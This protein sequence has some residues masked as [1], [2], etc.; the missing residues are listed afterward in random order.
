MSHALA[1]PNSLL[2]LLV[3][4][5]AFVGIS[6][7]NVLV[8]PG[9]DNLEVGVDW[10]ALD[11]NDDAL[12]DTQN[13]GSQN[14]VLGTLADGK[15]GRACWTFDLDDT[16]DP[17]AVVSA[18]LH[19]QLKTK[20]G[21]LPANASLYHSQTSTVGGSNATPSQRAQIYHDASFVD[22]G[23]DLAEPS[24]PNGWYSFDVTSQVISDL[25]N[26]AGDCLA[27]FR[28]NIDGVERTSDLAPGNRYVFASA[29]DLPAIRPYLE[30][31]LADAL[32]DT[33]VT[34]AGDVVR[35]VKQVGDPLE[36]IDYTVTNTGGQPASFTVREAE[37]CDWM[38]LSILGSSAPLDPNE[39]L[40][41]TVSFDP[42]GLSPGVY[43]GDIVFVNTCDP[44]D[45]HTSQVTL[46]YLLNPTQPNIVIIFF[47]DLRAQE[48]NAWGQS[49]IPSL[50]TSPNID[51]LA[52]EGLR[53]ANTFPGLPVCTPSRATL[54]TG[55]MPFAVRSLSENGRWMVGNSRY[56]DPNE[57]TFAEQLN[58]LGYDT[59]FVGKWHLDELPNLSAIPPERRQGWT[60]MTGFQSYGRLTDAK[61]FEDD[62]TLVEEP[63][64][65][66]PD[67]ELRYALEFIED[68]QVDPFCLLL[69]HGPPHSP[70]APWAEEHVIEEV[71]TPDR[72]Y[73]WDMFSS[74]PV[75]F[76][77]NMTANPNGYPDPARQIRMYHALLRGVDEN[78]AIVRNKLETLGLAD[79]TIVIFFSDHGVQLGSFGTWEKNV[80]YEESILCPLVIYDPRP[81]AASGVVTDLVS[82]ADFAPTI[83]ELAGGTPHPR[84]QGR[85]LAPFLDGSP[86]DPP[87]DAV[88]VQY[89]TMRFEGRGYARSRVLRTQ[90]WKLVACEVGTATCNLQIK[91]LFDLANDPYELSNLVD[92]PNHA[93]I[94][95][96]LWQRLEQEMLATEDPLLCAMNPYLEAN[97]LTIESSALEGRDLTDGTF[98][99]ENVGTG[100]ISYTITTDQPWL[101][102]SPSSGTSSGET[103]SITIDY[104]TA[105]LPIGGP[106]TAKITVTSPEALNT[107]E[108]IDVALRV[109]ATGRVAI[110]LAG[111]DA[112]DNG[113]DIE[114]GITRSEPGDGKTTTAL[115]NGRYCRTAA[116]PND[117][118]LYLQVDDTYAFE[119]SRSNL[120]VTVSY[121]DQG[122]GELRLQYDGALAAYANGGTV[123][124]TNTGQ[125][126]THTYHLADVYFG[127]RENGQSDFRL[128]WPDGGGYVDTVELGETP[129]PTPWIEV[130]PNAVS[131]AVQVGTNPADVNLTLWNSG[132]GK[133]AY[134]LSDDA[135]WLSAPA[136]IATNIGE[137]DQVPLTFTTA[138]LPVGDATAILTIQAPHA[139]N[140]PVTVPVVA[141]I[142][143]ALAIAADQDNDSD[144]DADD[145]Q[146]VL[147]CVSGPAQTTTCPEADLNGDG[148]TDMLDI[149]SF[150][151][152]FGGTDAL[153]G[154]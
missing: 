11:S 81:G 143:T 58:E 48:V 151:R 135:S 73:L 26:D 96:Q 126:L 64:T 71:F 20:V 84:M 15:L 86:T 136:A 114:A 75:A 149:A 106:Y 49:S 56:M 10:H 145:S 31:V 108:V 47:D 2:A 43:Q 9:E 68:H 90:T 67:L 110:D 101:S 133:V 76:R 37:P 69:N 33:T 29:D 4:L 12:G 120:Y 141:Q 121:F 98:T 92:D 93:A 153:P 105:A 78:I 119:G 52:A 139:G 116:T 134:T 66:L 94:Q 102:V 55:R 72:M 113:V 24:T 32:C 104:D 36:P 117:N 57:I 27:A 142:R 152:C 147:P 79:N 137:L 95:T 18:T 38:S 132:G 89:R 14:H 46:R 45:T 44:N 28:A 40:T 17:A 91:G 63:N 80:A 54:M 30:I 128:R 74:A 34:P 6:D 127:N 129:P 21:T 125:W 5:A 154:C 8:Y 82:L 148:F 41:V 39:A 144:V 138:S 25:A 107:V 7:A 115:I 112:A 124:L 65:W 85:S 123:G 60:W 88:M 122:T 35:V 150:Q 3:V 100:M 118:Y 22:T 53:F 13:H 1:K 19:V 87:R 140:T 146:Q 23:I 51:A 70:G 109:V 16:I 99:V 50:V 61:V 62:G 97:P 103:D 130:D 42:N 111:H 77:P 131:V 59:G 83:V